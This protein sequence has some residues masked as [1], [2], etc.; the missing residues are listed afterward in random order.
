MATDFN[1][2]RDFKQSLAK[3]KACSAHP[4]LR[5]SESVEEADLWYE[6]LSLCSEQ[7]R[8]EHLRWFALND[9]YFLAVFILHRWHLA[10]DGEWIGKHQPAHFHETKAERETRL[11]ARDWRKARWCFARARE[12]QDEPNNRFDLWSR[13][14]AKSEIITYALTIQ[15]IL[16]NPNDTFGFFSHNKAL[17]KKHLKLIKTEFET[18]HELQELFPD[19]LWSEPRL[20]APK[21]A[22]DAITVKRT[23]NLKEATVE[24]WGLVD[25]QPVS[26][27]F[28]KLVYDDVVARDEV[29]SDDKIADVTQEFENSLFLTASDPPIFRYQ[30]TY[31]E[32]NDTTAR[33][34]G[35][36]FGI[37][38]K[39]VGI[40]EDV[41]SPTFG[42][43]L[44]W[45]DEK[46]AYFKQ[47]Q[48]AKVFA[49]QVLLDPK[50]AKGDEHVGFEENALEYYDTVNL[51]SVLRYIFVDPAGASKDSNSY[52]ALAVVGLSPDHRYK[53][54]DLVYDKLDLD[55]RT[56]V[57]RER[58]Q[59]YDPLRIFYE[60]HAMQ[61]DI[62]HIRG[63]MRREMWEREIIPVGSNR[64]SKDQR[65]E[66][67]IPV[68]KQRLFHLPRFIKYRPEGTEWAGKEI[69][70]VKLFIE[71]EYNRWPYSEFK[72]I[73]DAL[74]RLKD[75]DVEI[76]LQW[77][78]PYGA[79]DTKVGG[80]GTLD[81]AG[82]W[83]SS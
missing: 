28:K 52:Y 49:L 82:G 50:K 80:I 71:R 46:L 59:R 21:W 35:R 37:L 64:V 13:E 51:N 26:S 74:S 1:P 9:L 29:S 2:L 20:E 4:P 12:V 43:A 42:Q 72:D 47:N 48:S 44:F 25:G 6:S 61:A 81:S 62:D 5:R 53:L 24:A 55:G 8:R 39:R 38:R 34:I 33:L 19:I 36:N 18:N 76:R 16:N 79:S 7:A 45:S 40:D 57:L 11:K 69:D 41:K 58:V 10:G 60:Q 78:R 27:R 73:L 15:D 65:I 54:L 77:P 32:V 66:W 70:L 56:R 30:A 23:S 3:T 17:A 14:H 31:Q 75:P 68:F 22:E 83:M 67:L 63:E